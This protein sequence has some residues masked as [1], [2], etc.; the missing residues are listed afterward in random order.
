MFQV[1]L[2]LFRKKKKKKRR[3]KCYTHVQPKLSVTCFVVGN[4]CLG[5]WSWSSVLIGQCILLQHVL[6]R[7]GNI[8]D[9]PCQ[10][11]PQS[12]EHVLQLCTLFREARR[13]QW[14]HGA[15]LQEQLWDNMEYLLKTITFV[16]TTGL[17]I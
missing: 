2:F 5:Q 16:Q 3:K 4:F 11:G 14:S 12:P 8:E 10:T 13:Q 17:T 9:C 1:E 7:T 6:T 15:T